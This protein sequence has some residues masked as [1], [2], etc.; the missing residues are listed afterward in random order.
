MVL[1]GCRYHLL[2]TVELEGGTL[3]AIPAPDAAADRAAPLAPDA[4][5]PVPVDAAADAGADLAAPDLG[6]D[7]AVAGPEAGRDGGPDGPRRCADSDLPKLLL[8]YSFDDC[9]DPPPPRLN[10]MAVP[11]PADATRGPATRC[12]PGRHGPALYFDGA[13]GAEVVVPERTSFKT[14]RVTLSLWVRPWRS[15]EAT[16]IGRWYYYD[17]FLLGYH[18][19]DDGTGADFSFAIGLPVPGNELGESV[20]VRAPAE[21]DLWTHLAGTFDGQYVR[22]FKNGNLFSEQKIPGGPRNM[23]DARRPITMGALLK[24]VDV[25]ENRFHGDLD[26]VRLYGVALTPKQI[27]LLANCTP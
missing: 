18:P 6:V 9:T 23:Q 2:G 5:E 1:G 12:I 20:S 19:R 10:D 3:Q 15:R 14:T 27:A 8:Y 26:E 16:V 4:A 25:P 22:L 17:A 24:G 13:P 7:A 11:G 21:D